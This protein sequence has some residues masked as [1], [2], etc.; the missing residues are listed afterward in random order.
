MERHPAY[1]YELLTELERKSSRFF[2]L[3]EGTL[4]PVLYRLEDDGLIHAQWSTDKIRGAPKKVYT[5]TPLGRR[6]LK[7]LC[8]IWEQFSKSVNDI[9]TEEDSSQ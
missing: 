6:E 3:R 9:L 4:Y 7:R 1:G 2:S 5:I 8:G